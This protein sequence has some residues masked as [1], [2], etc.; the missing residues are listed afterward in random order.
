[1]MSSKSGVKI[2]YVMAVSRA[3]AVKKAVERHPD[4]RCMISSPIDQKPLVCDLLGESAWCI[5][6]VKI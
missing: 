5:T 1:M 6:L 4:H 3:E 2:S